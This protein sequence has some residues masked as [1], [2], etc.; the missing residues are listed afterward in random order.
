MS[1]FEW[2][3]N[4]SPQDSI[5]PLLIMILYLELFLTLRILEALPTQKIDQQENL[6][7]IIISQELLNFLKG[8]VY[9]FM[10]HKEQRM[11]VGYQQSPNHPGMSNQGSQLMFI[12]SLCHVRERSIQGSSA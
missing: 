9:R 3:E 1:V 5:Y 2:C 10:S 12:G 7:K 11:T 4:R 6:G 8:R